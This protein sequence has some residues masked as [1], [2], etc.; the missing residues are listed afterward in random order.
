MDV[1][2]AWRDIPCDD[3][4]HSSLAERGWCDE[5]GQCWHIEPATRAYVDE[6][7]DLLVIGRPGVDGILWGYRKGKSGIWAYYPIEGRYE[8]V[9]DT[10]DDPRD[11]YS[12]GAITV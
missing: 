6:E 10:A 9:A 7:S 11:G 2:E 8:R 3:Y 5:P 12:S 4:C 1:P